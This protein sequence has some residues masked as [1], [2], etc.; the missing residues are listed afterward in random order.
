MYPADFQALRGPA[1]TDRTRELQALSA[2]NAK[3]RAE[4]EQV[5]A[6]LREPTK[7]PVPKLLPI[8]PRHQV[9]EKELENA[10]KQ[11]KLYEK[12]FARLQKDSLPGC[13]VG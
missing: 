5:Q 11:L 8:E 6:V 12:E 2:R 7:Q 9:L 3:L 13:S 1:L 10:Y 4:I